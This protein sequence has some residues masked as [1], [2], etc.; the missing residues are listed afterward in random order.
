MGKNKK[1]FA[2]DIFSLEQKQKMTIVDSDLR[3]EKYA[4]SF[5]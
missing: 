2:A 3:I 5:E 1:I 4:R